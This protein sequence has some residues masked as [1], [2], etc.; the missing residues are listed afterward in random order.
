MSNADQ[1]RAQL[2]GG[3]RPRAPARRRTSLAVGLLSCVL[4][5]D[6]AEHETLVPRRVDG[7][8]RVVLSQAERSA[9]DLQTVPARRG[10]LSLRSLRFGKASARPQEQVLVV[11]PATARLATPPSVALGSEVSEGAALAEIEPLPDGASRAGFAAQRRELQGQVEG[12]RARLRALQVEVSRIAT[13]RNS[14][15]ATEADA[16]R[17]AAELQAEQSRLSSLRR[18]EAELA[19]ISGKTVWLHAPSPGSVVSLMTAVGALI[20]QGEPIARIVRAGPRWIDV[21]AAPSDEPGTAYRARTASGWVSGRLLSQGGLIGS[22]GTRLDRI[23]V[24]PPDASRILPGA[25]LAIEVVREREGVLVPERA[26]VLHGSDP[27][28]FV[29]QE[30]GRFAPRRLRLGPRSDGQLIVSGVEPGERV[31]TR[32][33]PGLL[34]ELGHGGESAREGGAP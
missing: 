34:G 17:A 30:A 6:S 11:A 32:G 28:V 15:L 14:R 16:A 2:P 29:E 9:L 1:D 25:T 33:A 24:P 5:C 12:A 18:A 8:G 3:V 26:L 7:Q 31:V 4:A 20:R 19:A 27:I 23:E 13:L 22:D 21:A 10:T